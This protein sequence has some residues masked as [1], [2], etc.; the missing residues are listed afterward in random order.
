MRRIFL[1]LWLASFPWLAWGLPVADPAV[2]SLKTMQWG[3]VERSYYVHL[4]PAYDGKHPLPVLILLHGGG[5]SAPQALDSY[6]LREVADRQGFVL[7]AA[8]GTGPLR[9]EILRSWNVGWG[10]GYAQRHQVDD[11]GFLRALILKLRQTYAVE[12]HR[13]YLTGLSNG[14]I[15]CHFAGAANS[16]LVAGIAP[17]VGTVAGRELNQSKLV[18]PVAPKAPVNVIMFNGELDQHL[19]L[20]GGKQQLH[21]EE[22]VRYVASALQSAQFWVQANG[23]QPQPQVQE[24]PQQKATRYTWSG[25]RGGTRVI[26]YVLHNQGHAWPGG[27]APRAVA[28][29]PS[30]L[31]KAHQ[32]MWDF[33]EDCWRQ[34]GSRT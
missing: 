19:P 25:G 23:C 28:D 15:L 30:P 1:G 12:P 27:K 24:M 20:A 29:A 26:L 34:G 4:P 31:L 6:P 17:V 33:F 10:F 13:V 5:G 2:Y 16:D 22:Q 32:L 18:Y 21:A 7:V 14:A 11:V 9:R 3:G 8:N